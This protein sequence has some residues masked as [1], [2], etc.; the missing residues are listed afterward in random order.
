M[1]RLRLRTKL[2]L[3]L[4]L[5]SSFL[6]CTTLVIIHHIVKTQVRK[7]IFEDLQNSVVTFRNVLQQRQIMRAR[8]A[9]LI[10]DLPNLKA[11]MTSHDP[12]TIQDASAGT[13][14]VAGSDLFL[15]ADRE[16]QVVALHT[17]APGFTRAM[18]QEQ[19]RLHSERDEIATWWF[20]GGRLY[21]VFMQPVSFG[22]GAEK[23]VLGALAIG[24]DVDERLAR[25]VSRIA[26]S[27]VSI[28][29]GD[30]PIVSTLQP[31][32]ESAMAEV[33]RDTRLSA[34]PTQIALDGERFI[35][36]TLD[37]DTS[38][39]AV[40]LTVLKSYDQSAAFLDRLTRLVLGLGIAAVAFGSVALY[41]ICLNFTRPLENL[42]AGV[43]ALEAG[44]F[45]FPLESR[46]N[47]EVGV[48]S[49]AFGAMRRSLHQTQQK[50]LESER[51]ATIGLM[52][53]S[54]SHDLRHPLTA[55]L[56]NAEFLSEGRLAGGARE[57]LYE[58]IHTAVD[59]MI[60]LIDSLL[61]FSRGRE[62][63][64][65]SQGSLRETLLRAVRA[66]QAHPQF[67]EVKITVS[68]QCPDSCFDHRRLERAFYNLLLNACE[69]VAPDGR[70]EV[71]IAEAEGGA[72]IRISDNGPGIA[73]PIRDQLFRP[74]VSFGKENG[75]GLGLTIAHKILHDHGG[76]LQLASTSSQ[77]TTF[78]LTL[79]VQH[80]MTATRVVQTTAISGSL[81]RRS[82]YG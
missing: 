32:R 81:A 10:A 76:T 60:D 3:S 7:Q 53:S 6:T 67:L 49:N 13:W 2:E 1:A 17:S 12:I 35:A 28:A 69:A 37:L 78:E 77:G 48:V 72:R 19:L 55:I 64:Q 5:I 40:R 66:V 63:L 16:G 79:P 38:T 59:R 22:S 82:Q 42:A 36:S 18:A 41:F 33:R 57:D 51:L 56:A 34:T 75:T 20:G 52:A 46:S 29:Y 39:P 65:A 31:A 62:S 54:I 43:K 9:G 50:L 25:E 71:S 21:E 26:G 14:Q 45:S 70:I 27:E 58:E 47:D 68:G 24:Y 61:E 44:D 80:Q 30:T 73:E 15:L 11:L 8:S 4:L 74:F 23:S